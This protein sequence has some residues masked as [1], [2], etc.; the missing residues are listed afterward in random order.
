MEQIS[1]YLDE[2]IHRAVAD[3][4]Q[5]LQILNSLLGIQKS[6]HKAEAP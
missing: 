3:G 5:R 1:F 2:H 4:L 6:L